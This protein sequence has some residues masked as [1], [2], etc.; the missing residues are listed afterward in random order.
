MAHANITSE[1][2]KGAQQTQK[3]Y[4]VP[5]SVTLGQIILESSGSNP[6][7]LSGLAYKYNNLFGIK[8]GS[9]WTGKT[10]NVSTGEYGSGGAYQTK[11]D[12][13]VYDSIIDSIIDHGKLLTKPLYTK[14]TSN[15]KTSQDYAR[16]IKQAGYATDPSYADKLISIMDKY[17]FYQYDNGDIGNITTDSSSNNN[18][19]SQNTELVF[20]GNILLVVLVAI[21]V[22]I[23][24]TFF[25]G[26][27]GVNLKKAGDKK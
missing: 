25:A 24:V 21:M 12:F 2:I 14:Y 26:A 1:M 13:R 9:S 18:Q 17:N 7:N 20:W 6:G 22:V 10:V 5:A 11:S 3:Q 23:G 15:A 8:A 4:G 27:F 16:A 19:N